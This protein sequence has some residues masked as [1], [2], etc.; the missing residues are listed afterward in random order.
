[1]I[2]ILPELSLT[3]LALVVFLRCTACDELHAPG[4]DVGPGAGKKS[5]LRRCDATRQPLMSGTTNRRE[6]RGNRQ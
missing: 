4:D 2:A 1:V 3:T 5:L 6:A